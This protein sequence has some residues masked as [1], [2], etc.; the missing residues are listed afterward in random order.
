MQHL[1]KQPVRLHHDDGIDDH[2]DTAG[3]EALPAECCYAGGAR[4]V[5]RKGSAEHGIYHRHNHKLQG[6]QDVAGEEVDA[7]PLGILVGP[8]GN[9]Q[10]CKALIDRQLNNPDPQRKQ[11]DPCGNHHDHV[12]HKNAGQRPKE[13]DPL[14]QYA[15]D[16]DLGG[17]VSDICAGQRLCYIG[18]MDADRIQQA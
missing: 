2:K 5:C 11:H 12:I 15:D 6:K 10:R 4:Q 3:E 8:G 18:V 9:E 7:E 1:V 16:R 14:H 13:I 17:K